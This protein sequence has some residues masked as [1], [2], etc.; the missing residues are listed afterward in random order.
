MPNLIIQNAA[1]QT[2]DPNQ[3]T[4][5]AVVAE[6]NKIIFVGSNEDAANLRQPDSHMIDGAG[7]TLMPGIHD[8]HFHLFMGSMGIEDLRLDDVLTLERLSEVLR[9]RAAE[10]PDKEWVLGGGLIYEI[11]SDTE[12]LTRH[13]LDEILPN[14]PVMIRSVDMHTAW[15]NTMALERAGI[16][17]GQIGRAHV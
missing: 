10:Q 15:C 8:S 9:Q 7:R 16:L 13:H 17:H 12:P 5:E 6:G 11:V 3:P 4:A 2:I 1:V 14:R